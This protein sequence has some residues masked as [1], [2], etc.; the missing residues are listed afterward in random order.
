MTIPLQAG[1][2]EIAGFFV[3]MGEHIDDIR[4]TAEDL[5]QVFKEIL[6]YFENGDMISE[7]RTA[8][9]LIPSYIQEQMELKITLLK[10]VLATIKLQQLA[11]NI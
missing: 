5:E 9:A 4:A 2:N 11:N 3:H 6:S 8:L 7:L 1:I 10:K